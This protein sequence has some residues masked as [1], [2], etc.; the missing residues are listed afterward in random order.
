LANCSAIVPV[1]PARISELPPTAISAVF[2]MR[3]GSFFP[4]GLKPA[5]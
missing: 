1:S 2:D 4:Q 3:S 5:Y